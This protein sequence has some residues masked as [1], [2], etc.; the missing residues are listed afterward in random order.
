VRRFCFALGL[1]FFVSAVLHARSGCCS[2][3]GGVCGCACCDGTPLSETC[4]PYYPN[5][6]GGG[7]TVA[8]PSSL[9]ASATSSSSCVLT[10]TDNSSGE[11]DFQIEEE[12]SDQ[13]SFALIDTVGANMTSATINNLVPAT[14][15]SFRVRAQSGSSN[16]DYSNQTTVTTLPDSA[17][18]CEPPFICFNQGRFQVVANWKT[19]AGQS[20]TGNV[21][22]LTD[23]SGYMW[24]FD[25]SNVEVVFKVIDAC[26]LTHPAYWFFAGGL[27][28]V[29][30]SL[31]VTDTKTGVVKTYTNPQGTPFQPVQ[32]NA[33]F[34]TCP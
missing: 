32:D 12:R 11:A 6:G 13:T 10:W 19:R 15:Y 34:G 5:C 14:T 16:S 28:N 4:L 2:H 24:F 1:L 23:E 7:G 22:R 30:V 3:H 21:V 33:A 20:G 9:G 29:E 18:L 31:T 8:A 27:T 26:T 25:P 17:S